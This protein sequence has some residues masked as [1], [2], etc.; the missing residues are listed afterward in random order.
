V[1]ALVGTGNETQICPSGTTPSTGAA[2]NVLSLVVKLTDTPP[3]TAGAPRVTVPVTLPPGA[4]L[5]ESNVSDARDED[6]VG[7]MRNQIC[8]GGGVTLQVGH[9]GVIV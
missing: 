4:G 7:F 6:G 8:C 3:A 1:L 5:A 2:T 9:A